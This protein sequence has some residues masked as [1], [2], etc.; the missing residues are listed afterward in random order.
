MNYVHE[1]ITI[2]P[3]CQ[4]QVGYFAVQNR[5]R[6]IVSPYT[7]TLAPTEGGGRVPHWTISDWTIAHILDNKILSA[8]QV[9]TPQWV[10]LSL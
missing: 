2:F 8:Y 3:I 5:S 4:G 9:N 7:C 1:D 10:T 6:P